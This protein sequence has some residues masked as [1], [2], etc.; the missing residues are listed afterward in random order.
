MTLS[1]YIREVNP[2]FPPKYNKHGVLSDTGT[3][4]MRIP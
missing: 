4:D 3:I 1:Q 2:P